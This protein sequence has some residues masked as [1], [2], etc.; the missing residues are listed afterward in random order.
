MQALAEGRISFN[1]AEGILRMLRT[2][3]D[4]IFGDM[5][6]QAYKTVWTREYEAEVQ[7]DQAII[8]S[9]VCKNLSE[10]ELTVMERV[11]EKQAAVVALLAK[12]GPVGDDVTK[13]EG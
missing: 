4:A 10:E 13:S 12:G 8:S 6:R 11:L 2:F 5:S 7:K 1:E 9:L 3:V